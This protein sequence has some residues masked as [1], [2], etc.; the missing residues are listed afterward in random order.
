MNTMDRLNLIRQEFDKHVECTKLTLGKSLNSI[1]RVSSLIVE[2][3][4]L[5]P[6]KKVILFGNGGSAADCQHIAAEFTNRFSIEREPLPAI[7]LTTDTSAITAISND[8][9]FNEIFVKQI[10]AIGN[11][12]DIAIGI[13][14]SGT[15]NNVIKALIQAKQLKMKTILL[16]GIIKENKYKFDEII[17]VSSFSTPR[18]QEMHIFIGHIICLLIDKEYEKLNIK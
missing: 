7:A 15:S 12:G 6:R 17:E 8:Y 11:E 9:D 16:T 14:T 5:Q 18:I 13:S 4:K 3:F 1:E 2:G 10:K